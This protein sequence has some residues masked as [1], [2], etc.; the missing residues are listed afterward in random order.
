[1]NTTGVHMLKNTL[2]TVLPG[3]RMTNL[4]GRCLNYGIQRHTMTH[5]NIQFISHART[6]KK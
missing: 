1:M 3:G 4:R 5:G 2:R 6:L